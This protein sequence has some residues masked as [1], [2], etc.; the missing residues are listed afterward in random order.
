M[1]L[2]RTAEWH[3]FA[4]LWLHTKSTLQHLKRLTTELGQFMWKFRDATQSG[5]L[6]F[7]LPKET[8]AHNQHQKS[9]KGKEKAVAGNTSEHKPKILNLFTYKWHALGDYIH[10][11]CL[12][13]GM[14]G[15]STQVVSNTIFTYLILS[16]LLAARVN[17]LIKLLNNCMD[18]PTNAMQSDKLPCAIKDLNVPIWRLTGSGF[19]PI[20]SKNQWITRMIRQRVTWICSITSLH[21]KID[22]WT[23]LTPFGITEV[24]LLTMYAALLIPIIVIVD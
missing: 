17:L 2:Y 21:Q 9:G 20:L 23:Y 16:Q 22:L 24:T 18:R 3:A 5:F 4:K 1:L 10:T 14:D 6:T 8:G 12:F 15:F 7:K 13:G 19:M 11:I